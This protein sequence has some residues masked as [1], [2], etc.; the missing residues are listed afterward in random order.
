MMPRH[1]SLLLAALLAA[2]PLSAP[3]ATP[4]QLLADYAAQAQAPGDPERGRRLFTG[5]HG[6]E[7]RCASCHGP[8]PV[9][10]GKHAATGKVIAPMAPAVNSERFTEVAKSDKWFRR[11]C[12]DVIGRECTAGEKADVLSWLLSLRS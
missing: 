1:L 7:W 6:H 10:P 12:R 4:A 11:N 3:A 8:M 9:T 2:L 5:D